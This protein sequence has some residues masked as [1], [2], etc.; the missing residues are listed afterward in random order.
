MSDPTCW[1]PGCYNPRP[2][3]SQEQ[4]QRAVEFWEAIGQYQ[5]R[6][7]PSRYHHHCTYCYDAAQH[8]CVACEQDGR[9]CTC[10]YCEYCDEPIADGHC[11]GQC[12]TNI[13]ALRTRCKQLRRDLDANPTPETHRELMR[14]AEEYATHPDATDRDRSHA[15]ALTDIPH[16]NAQNRPDDDTART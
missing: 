16:R 11:D 4:W 8:V 1:T 9:Y 3:R 13:N 12:G 7:Y 10:E 5:G 15:A 6:A 2:K 14:V